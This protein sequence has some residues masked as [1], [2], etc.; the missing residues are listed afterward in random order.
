MKIY[1]TYDIDFVPCQIKFGNPTT[2]IVD[3]RLLERDENAR[4]W[5]EAEDKLDKVWRDDF[6]ICPF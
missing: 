5:V 1:K 4:R 2:D 3:I 6:R